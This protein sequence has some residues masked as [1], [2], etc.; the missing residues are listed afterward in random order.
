MPLTINRQYGIVLLTIYPKHEKMDSAAD[1]ICR[2]ITSYDQQ[3][4]EST[5]DA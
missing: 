2:I 3:E 1:E 5:E 4:S